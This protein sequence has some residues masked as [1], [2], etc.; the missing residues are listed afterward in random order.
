VSQVR[1]LTLDSIKPSVVRRLKTLGN[2]KVNAVYEASLP[3]DF[4]KTQLKKGENRHEFIMEKYVSMKYVL[5]T[6]KERIL[7]ESKYALQ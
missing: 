4:D 7:I 1:S 3:K 5:P 2:S 6:D